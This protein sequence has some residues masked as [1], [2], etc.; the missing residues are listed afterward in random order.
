MAHPIDKMIHDLNNLNKNKLG[1]T[2]QAEDIRG[3][4]HETFVY[5]KGELE[6]A[7]NTGYWYYN[8]QPHTEEDERT[9]KEYWSDVLML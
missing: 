1:H 4:I 2:Q 3:K 9:F 5:E 8:D 7:R 6:Y